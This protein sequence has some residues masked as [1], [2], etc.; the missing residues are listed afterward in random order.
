[1]S[2]LR[3]G[4]LASRAGTNLQALLD[5]VHGRDG[6]EVVAVAS[7]EPAAPALRRAE[8]AGRRDPGLHA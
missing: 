2:G 4:V 7:N 5:T 6:I 3:V 8:D 1:M